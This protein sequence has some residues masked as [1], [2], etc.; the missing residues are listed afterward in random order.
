M[1]GKHTLLPIHPSHWII[2]AH[3]DG[4]RYRYCEACGESRET[5]LTEPCTS[6]D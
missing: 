2:Y 3:K 6:K 5:S 4:K 1:P